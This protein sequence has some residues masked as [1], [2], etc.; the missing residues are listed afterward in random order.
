MATLVPLVGVCRPPIDRL[1]AGPVGHLKCAPMNARP[2]Q[3]FT[4]IELMV[5][6]AVLAI[7]LGLA[8]PSFRET[9][10]NS[11]TA[12]QTNDLV[13][14]LN[15]AKSEANK[16]G[17]AVSVCAAR[18][19]NRDSCRT[20]NPGDWSNGWLVFT[21]RLNPGTRDNGESILMPSDAPDAGFTVTTGGQGFVRFAP[22]GSVTHNAGLVIA[23][24]ANSC[25]NMRR[26]DVS[27]NAV[28]RIN[29]LK[30]DCV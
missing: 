8:A 7:L 28:G 11:K 25:A 14:A 27:V 2:R 24:Q 22:S 18:D 15:L 26:R 20:A 9:L 12:T 17:F 19:A 5:T 10:L 1:P 29:T 30:R 21:D 13:A 3:G 4:L 23:V 16:R 6:V